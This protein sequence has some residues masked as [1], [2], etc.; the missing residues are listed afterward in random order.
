MK[1][2]KWNFAVF[3]AIILILIIN[4][5]VNAGE[6][7]ISTFPEIS[8]TAIFDTGEE[9]RITVP[10]ANHGTDNDHIFE[11]FFGM[12]LIFRIALTNKAG[13]IRLR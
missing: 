4:F 2:I 5:A 13:Q 10:L 3:G 12:E 7:N 8:I 9:E 1:N 6:G 11:S